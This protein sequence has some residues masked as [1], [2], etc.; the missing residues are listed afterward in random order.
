M[1]D[2]VNDCPALLMFEVMAY[3]STIAYNFNVAN[4]LIKKDGSSQ[5][6]RLMHSESMD[7]WSDTDEMIIEDVET[8]SWEDVHMEVCN[9]STCLSCTGFLIDARPIRLASFLETQVVCFGGKQTV[10]LHR[11]QFR[12]CHESLC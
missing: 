12:W 6:Q 1:R 5:T 10:V 7:S 9:S 11:Y 3:I 2:Q 8:F 4:G